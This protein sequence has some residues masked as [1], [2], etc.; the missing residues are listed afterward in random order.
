[1]GA[2]K[3]SADLAE[4]ERAGQVQVVLA[5]LADP[6]GPASLIRQ[7]GDRIDVLVNNVGGAPTRTRGFLSITD[8]DWHAT[9]E[10]DL[11]AA[12]R[13]TRAALPGMLAAGTGVAVASGVYC[14]GLVPGPVSKMTS[15][16]PLRRRS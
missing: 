5:D 2:R 14:F 16:C 13:A 12:V 15:R 11:M 8:V 3:S 9:I 1:M 6:A 7:A 10:L 4:L